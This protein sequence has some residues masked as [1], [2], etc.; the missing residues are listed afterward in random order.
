MFVSFGPN[1]PAASA[2][3]NSET[4]G[5]MM[6]AT[7]ELTIAVNAEPMTTATARSMTLPRR[8]KSLKP[9]SMGTPNES[10]P[11]EEAGVD[12]AAGAALVV[13]SAFDDAEPSF[14]PSDLARESVR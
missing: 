14:D 1:S 2:S 8:M 7:T 6:L 9:L 13:D 10:R 11:Q 4:S 5:V 3:K 12:A